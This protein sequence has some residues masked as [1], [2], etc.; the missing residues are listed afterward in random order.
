MRK[1]FVLLK[2]NELKISV[3]GS[4]KALHLA[5]NEYLNISLSTLQHFDFYHDYETEN[6]KIHADF[7]KTANEIRKDLGSLMV[8]ILV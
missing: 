6:Y 8:N 4:L 5:N 1:T 3:Y 7:A 2:K